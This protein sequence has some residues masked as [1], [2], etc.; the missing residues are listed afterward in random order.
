[1]LTLV[2]RLLHVAI[3]MHFFWLQE[4]LAR[5]SKKNLAFSLCCLN[6]R[7]SLPTM[8]PTPPILDFLLNP[9]NGSVSKNF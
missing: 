5:S 9:N 6:G 7:V 4:R 2:I 8:Q 3:V 1:M